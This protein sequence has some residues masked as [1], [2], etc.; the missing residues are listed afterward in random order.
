MNPEIF[1]EWMRRQ[2][3][4]VIKTE[5]SY[6]YDAS[7]RVYQ[8]FPYHWIIHPTE[9]ELTSLLTDNQAIALRY[10]TSTDHQPG[11]ISYHVIYDKPAYRIEELDRRSKQ[12]IRN[13]L[14]N[15]RVEQISLERLASEGWELESDTVVR[16]KRG[17]LMKSNAWKKR[18]LDAIDLPGFEA[19]ASIVVDR[20]TATLFLFQMEDCC[21]LISQQ[22]HRDFMKLKVNNALTFVVTEMMI[23]RRKIGLIFYTLQSLDAPPSVDEYKFRMGYYAKPVRQRV[24]FHPRIQSLA[25]NFSLR[26]LSWLQRRFPRVNLLAKGEGM[27]KFYVDGQ[28]NLD[29]QDWPP[30]LESY[31]SDIQLAYPI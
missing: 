24:V 17:G 1:A 15:C 16:Q 21:E 31:R 10:S 6:W 27:L 29:L 28:K 9:K 14:N 23:M 19:W 8:A 7:P 11:N 26:M 20:L 4:N 12:N 5:S 13:G 18:F 22:C 3:H 2:G 25:N 30:C